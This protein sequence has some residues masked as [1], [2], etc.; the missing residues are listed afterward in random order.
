MKILS[1]RK[2]LTCHFDQKWGRR[3][4][5]FGGSSALGSRAVNDPVALCADAVARWHAS[6]LAAL[7]LS[8]DRDAAAWRAR[9]EPP[10]IYFAGITLRPEASEEAVANVPG[11]ICDAWQT[12]DLS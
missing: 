3:P 4:P 9:D 2:G 11:N 1:D 5:Q 7:G 12:L 8:S 6:W 10:L